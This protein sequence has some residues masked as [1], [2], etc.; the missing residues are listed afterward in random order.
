MLKTFSIRSAL[1]LNFIALA[2]CLNIQMVYASPLL[3]IP[4]QEFQNVVGFNGNEPIS[5]NLV[6]TRHMNFMI[7]KLVMVVALRALMLS[8]AIY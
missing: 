7:I 5:G 2:L 8:L 3:S 1:P 4:D 6:T